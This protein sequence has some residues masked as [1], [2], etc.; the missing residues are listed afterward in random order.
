MTED[1]L[2]P[3]EP[4][5]E[6]TDSPARPSRRRGGPGGPETGERDRIEAGEGEAP[7]TAERE[8]L[9]RAERRRARGDTGEYE[10][11]GRRPPPGRR[12]RRRDL[13]ARVRRRQ[14]IAVGAAALAVLVGGVALVSGGGD[15]E[16]EEQTP[17][18]KLIGQTLV[19]RMDQNGPNEQLIR[20]VRKGQ[21]GGLLV[22]ARDPTRLQEHV[23]TVQ[24]AAREGGNPPLLIMIDQEGGPVKRLP[25]PPNVSP[26]ELGET[27]DTTV[28]SAEGQATAE[29]LQ[30]L[31]VDIDL[32]PVLDVTLPRTAET[33]ASRTFGDDAAQVSEIGVAFIEGLQSGG[34]AG[35]AKHFPGLGPSTVNPD[36]G[37]ATVVLTPAE[38]ETALL[39]F[40]DAVEAGVELVMVSTAIYPNLGSQDPAALSPTIVQGELRQNLGFEG[41]IITDDLEAG[42]ITDETT[43]ERAAIQAL[44]A[45]ND[46]LLFARSTDT[47]TAALKAVAR[48]V[49]SRQLDL[50]VVDDAYRQVLVLKISLAN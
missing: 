21:V 45:G 25:G 1:R 17:L 22:L 37:R 20:Q 23:A 30:P 47:V 48:A 41:T 6:W 40:R 2:P 10:R 13:P 5:F 39:P 43:P 16:E 35:T 29:L 46:L 36:D 49:K 3:D 34:V 19:G 50:A 38:Q 28:A 44:T 18:K 24:D 7:D 31:G 33:I 11:A 27:G 32:A 9:S 12:T 42:A 15:G 14:D 8:R 26:N 4:D